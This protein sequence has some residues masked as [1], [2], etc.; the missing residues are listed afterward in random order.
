MNETS[1]S[2][3]GAIILVVLLLLLCGT[4][5]YI[6][7][8]NRSLKE[9]SQKALLEKEV[10][11]QQAMN[12]IGMFKGQNA[13]LD[14]MVAVA[15]QELSS[16][17]AA[18]DSLLIVSRLSEKQLKKFK[19]ENKQLLRFKDI[20]LRKI[21][22]LIQANQ[23][24]LAENSGLKEEL[25]GERATTG[26]LRDEN[27]NLNSK[28]ALGSI[29]KVRDFKMTG[30]RQSGKNEKTISKAKRVE[31]LKICLTLLENALAKSGAR[32]V[33]IRIMDANGVPMFEDGTGSGSTTLNGKEFKYTAMAPVDYTQ[34]DTPL[35]VY[36]KKSG[37][38]A[39][40][41]YKAEV[42]CD[43]QLLGTSELSLK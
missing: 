21:D 30:V 8:N 26:Q 43:G 25:S 1:N 13:Q 6:W 18:L 5:F 4:L 32:M 38:W 9:E 39:V 24:L 34:S 35:C 29:L 17:S 20:Y 3:K 31:K 33:Y 23:A 14:S 11:V 42:Y 40:G 7:N 12:E 15:Q 2:K 36:W 19:E 16:K 22:S 37:T 41:N 28:V 10:Q 27:A